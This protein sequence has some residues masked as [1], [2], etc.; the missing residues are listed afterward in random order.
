MWKYITELQIPLTVVLNKIDKLGN[1]DKKNSLEHTQKLLF[2]Q[3]V[4]Q[5]SAQSGE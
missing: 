4:E 1:Q 3:K 5:V 2:G